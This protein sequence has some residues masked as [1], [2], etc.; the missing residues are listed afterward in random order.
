MK[1]LRVL[2]LP[3]DGMLVHRRFTP[4]NMSPV[5]IYTPGWRETMWGKVSWMS[6][7]TARWQGVGVKPP[8]FRSEVQRANRYTTVPPQH[9]GRT[10]PN[11][12]FCSTVFLA[13]KQLW[14]CIRWTSTPCLQVL[15]LLKYITE[16]K[17]CEQ[18]GILLRELL[19]KSEQLW[20]INEGS[21]NLL[22]GNWASLVKN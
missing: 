7:E 11:V 10:Y 20:R 15:P 1:Q 12:H 4:S 5:P 18:E 2:L 16:S 17:I 14:C 19:E 9:V 22:A 3:L 6:R 8:T 13:L 21:K